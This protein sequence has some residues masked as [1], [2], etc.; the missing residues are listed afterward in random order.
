MNL[1]GSPLAAARLA[2]RFARNPLWQAVQPWFMALVLA[3]L[4]VRLAVE[5]RRN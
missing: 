2:A 1:P 4:A 3:G 5:E